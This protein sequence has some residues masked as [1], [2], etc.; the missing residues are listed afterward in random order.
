MFCVT[1]NTTN[2]SILS[3]IMVMTSKRYF[4]IKTKWQIHRSIFLKSP[5]IKDNQQLYASHKECVTR[6]LI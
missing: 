2:H 6:K 1:Q 3:Y 4:D 5:L